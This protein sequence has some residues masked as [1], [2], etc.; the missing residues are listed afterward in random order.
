[1][2][3]IPAIDL[4]D[5]KCVRLYQGDFEQATIYSDDPVAVARQWV[6]Q[7]ATRLHVVDLDGARSGR[8]VNTDTVLTIVRAV[9]VPVQLGGGLRDEADIAAA[10]ALGVARVILGTVAVQN[11][12]LVERL[13]A[14]FGDQIIVGV[15]AQ[16]GQVAITGWTTLAHFQASDLVAQ[17]TR[18]GVQRIIYTDIA[19][20]GTLTEPDFAA[21]ANLVHPTGPAIIASGGVSHVD[22]VRRLATTGVEAVIIGRAL[23]TGAIDLPAALAALA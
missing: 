3:I 22:H 20:D 18:M 15:D 21:T 5:G 12:S 7:G 2:E 10:L 6:A 14:R 13:V 4:K 19:R 16:N 1:M 23:Y 8:P 11:P 17:M 9:D